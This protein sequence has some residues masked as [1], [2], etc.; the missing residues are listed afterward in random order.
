MGYV[1]AGIKEIDAAPV[2][3]TITIDNNRASE[4]LPGFEEMRP[5]VFAGLFPV[6]AANQCAFRKKMEQSFGI[7]FVG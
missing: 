4:T 5:R 6:R 2:G 1:I 3:D 7:V